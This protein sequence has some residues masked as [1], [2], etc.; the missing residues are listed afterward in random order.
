MFSPGRI[1]DRADCGMGAT[2]SVNAGTVTGVLVGFYHFLLTGA[3]NGRMRSAS[4]RSVELG[5]LY[6]F[7]LR[8]VAG[9]GRCRYPMLLFN[10]IATASVTCILYKEIATALRTVFKSTGGIATLYLR[11]IV[12]DITSLSK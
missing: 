3:R 12:C 4:Q 6:C 10:R 7:S 9:W 1:V 11:S 8:W 5:A 2:E